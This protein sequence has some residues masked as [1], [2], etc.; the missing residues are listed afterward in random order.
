MDK[1]LLV[2]ILGEQAWFLSLLIS[3]PIEKSCTRK[4]SFLV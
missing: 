1:K 3:Y 2:T 4:D